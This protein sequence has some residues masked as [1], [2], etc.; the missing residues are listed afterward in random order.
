MTHVRLATA[1]SGCDASAFGFSYFI[2]VTQVL[3]LRSPWKLGRF[4]SLF[5]LFLS[6]ALLALFSPI[7]AEYLTHKPILLFLNLLAVSIPF[8]CH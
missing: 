5:R 8:N 4:S 7:S 1:V 3:H 6:P 2:C